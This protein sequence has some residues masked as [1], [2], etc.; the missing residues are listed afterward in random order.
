IDW[1]SA[2]TRIA[3]ASADSSV[4][5]WD[6]ISQ[7]SVQTFSLQ[8]P[9]SIIDAITW[10]PVSDQIIIASNSDYPPTSDITV[11]DTIASQQ[12]VVYSTGFITDIE[13][14]PITNQLALSVSDRVEILDT[15]TWQIIETY[16]D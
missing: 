6:V 14:S 12:A 13:W 3:S 7:S 9:Y 4:I 1:S 16:Q 8:E 11:W 5:I 10:N 15:S 2:G